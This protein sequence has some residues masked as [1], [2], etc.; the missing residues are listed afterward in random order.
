MEK[1]A[2]RGTSAEM[3]S[4]GLAERPVGGAGRRGPKPRSTTCV[5]NLSSIKEIYFINHQPSVSKRMNK[6]LHT[7]KHTHNDYTL[8]LLGVRH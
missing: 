7:H 2:E 5:I 1:V 4:V 6:L 8:N 3:R